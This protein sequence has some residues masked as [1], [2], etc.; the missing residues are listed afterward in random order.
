MSR[1]DEFP[2]VA[3][4]ELLLIEGHLKQ[5]DAAEDIEQEHELIEQLIFHVQ[6]LKRLAQEAIE[7]SSSKSTAQ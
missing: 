5:I 1:V 6:H 3:L 4:W 7:E 2:A